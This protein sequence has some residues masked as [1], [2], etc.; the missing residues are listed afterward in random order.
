MPNH[1][2]LDEILRLDPLKDH[3]RIAYLFAFHEFPWDT[4][5]WLEL[6][7]FRSFGMAK[8][9]PLLESTGE[10][11]RR[12]QKRYDDT[13]LILAEIAEHGYDSPRGREAL[14]QMNR[15]HH[16]YP[17]PN[18]EFL[19]VLSCFVFEPSRWI[20][21]FG[22]RPLTENEKLA[23]FYYWRE[24]GRRMN[25]KDI[26]DS[27]EELERFNVEFERAHYRY[28]P[29]NYRLAVATRNLFLG[30][31][32]PKPLW[33]LG[34]P[35]I[36]ALMDDALLDACGLPRPPQWMRRVTEGLVRLRGRM[37]RLLPERREPRL[38]TRQK[39][40][41]YPGGY[42]IEELGTLRNA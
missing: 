10:F 26:P 35:F 3:Q 9:T 8:G 21:R 23:A 27:I 36:H 13:G 6:A 30:W 4:T 20:A 7:L 38:I 29:S 39:H 24:L 22:W 25:I 40:P 19:Y 14:R 28:A 42:G 12:T 33:P 16:R 15:M 31:F 32:L 2:A 1:A 17:I 11:T 41:T 18:D 37:V 5:R 34:A